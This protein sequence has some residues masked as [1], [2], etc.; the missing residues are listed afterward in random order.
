MKNENSKRGGSF[1]SGRAGSDQSSYKWLVLAVVMVGTF[2]VI[3]DS[4]IVNVALPKIMAAFGIPIDTA[5]WVLN[6]YLISFGALLPASGWFADRFG[7][8]K[9]FTL[10]LI[11]FTLGSFL[12]AISWD[13]KALMFFRVFQ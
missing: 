13:E 11:I 10:S 2:M 8:R 7:Y 5:E 4:S 9:I 3:L 1:G 12:C 6:G